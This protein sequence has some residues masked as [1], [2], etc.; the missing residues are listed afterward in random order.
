MQISVLLT[1]LKRDESKSLR[2][3]NVELGFLSKY[4]L[5]HHKT[6]SV[7]A[8]KRLNAFQSLVRSAVIFVSYVY[9]VL[10]LLASETSGTQPENF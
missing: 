4:I 1:L 5:C 6:G 2:I 9:R 10:V 8:S 7:L 3:L